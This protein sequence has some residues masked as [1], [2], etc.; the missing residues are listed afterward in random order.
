[1]LT[2]CP[3][4]NIISLR[5]CCICQNTADFQDLRQ[6]SS[7]GARGEEPPYFCI[8]QCYRA[9]CRTRSCHGHLSCW[10][11]H[12]PF[13]EN[14]RELHRKID[15]LPQIHVNAVTYSEPDPARQRELHDRDRISQWF[16]VKLGTPEREQ[17][18][19]CVSDRFRQLCDPGISGNRWTSS[20]YPSFVSFIGDTGTGN[21]RW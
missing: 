9:D 4:Q 18:R 15:Q 2:T 14:L 1:L 8:R 11:A 13:V 10:E 21:P 20:L 17:A 6:C 3:T 19:I 5:T 16:V 7:C 12:L